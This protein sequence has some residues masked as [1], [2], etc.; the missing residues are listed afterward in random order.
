MKDESTITTSLL[1]EV[2]VKLHI[3]S[4]T[5]TQVKNLWMCL[6]YDQKPSV[7]HIVEHIRKNLCTSFSSADLKS[8]GV[9]PEVKLYL[10]EFWLPNYESSRLIRE[11]D[12]VK[13]ITFYFKFV[14]KYFLKIMIIE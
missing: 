14:Y 6:N 7:S 12:C 2:R 13:Y 3:K 9:E 5:D 8:R 1:N 11:N 4:N 10:D